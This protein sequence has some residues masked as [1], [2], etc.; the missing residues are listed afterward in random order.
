MM[1]KFGSIY[2]AGNMLIKHLC[3]HDNDILFTSAFKMA[4]PY[5]FIQIYTKALPIA[6]QSTKF[7]L[8]LYQDG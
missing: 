2:C 8:Y 5:R 6:I 7:L 3:V 4:E 1:V